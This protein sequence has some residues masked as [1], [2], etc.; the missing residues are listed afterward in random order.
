VAQGAVRN[1]IEIHWQTPP[2][3]SRSIV[4]G[5]PL[6]V[7]KWDRSAAKR[8]FGEFTK[9]LELRRRTAFVRRFS[10][11]FSVAVSCRGIV[12]GHF[13]AT[14]NSHGANA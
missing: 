12:F 11:R 1:Q 3:G 10:Y 4:H 6:A 7:R 9:L 5:T 8:D 2:S 14:E 13:S